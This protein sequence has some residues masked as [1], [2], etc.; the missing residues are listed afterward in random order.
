MCVEH[1][2]YIFLYGNMRPA[3]ASPTGISS[4]RILSH[5]RTGQSLPGTCEPGVRS[6]LE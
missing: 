1:Y 4:I 6:R 2:I 5:M 3:R